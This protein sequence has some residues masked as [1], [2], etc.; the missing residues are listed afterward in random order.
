LK[1]RGVID[2]THLKRGSF[3]GQ[4]KFDHLANRQCGSACPFDWLAG[5]KIIIFTD[6]LLFGFGRI[7]SEVVELAFD[8]LAPLPGRV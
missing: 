1:V 7:G 4:K 8:F 3:G 2:I 5:E 6:P